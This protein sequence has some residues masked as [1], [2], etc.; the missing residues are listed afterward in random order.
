MSAASPFTA[1]IADLRFQSTVALRNGLLKVASD[2][3]RSGFHVVPVDF[4]SVSTIL[5]D[6][7]TNWP[8]YGF[9][10]GGHGMKGMPILQGTENR[11]KIVIRNAPTIILSPETFIRSPVYRYGLVFVHGCF[12]GAQEWSRL[13]SISADYHVWSGTIPST[14]W[15]IPN[16]NPPNY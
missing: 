5:Q 13:A 2:Y 7:E 14:A 4:T 15:G 8:T 10:L 16:G 12:A 1:L 11:G 6:R 3:K 9:V